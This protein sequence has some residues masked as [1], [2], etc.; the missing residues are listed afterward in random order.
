MKK[1]DS[2]D[3]QKH[4][5]PIKEAPGE[6]N[7]Q[8]N[9]AVHIPLIS[10][11]ISGQEPVS[12]AVMEPVQ[13]FSRPGNTISIRDALNPLK[14]EQKK[15]IEA[16]DKHNS[17]DAVILT[18]RPVSGEFLLLCWNSFAENIRE[19]RPRMS[20]ALKSSPP[21]VRSEAIVEFV[22]N[23]QAQLEDFS[24]STKADLEHFLRR[25]MQNSAI[26]IE[27]IVPEIA[28]DQKE[29]LY[30]SEEKFEYLNKKNP[31]LSKL[32]ERLNLELE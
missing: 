4:L 16:D 28:G 20:A 12:T 24:R 26:V 1:Q 11:E 3:A 2:S 14:T 6:I 13:K 22:L 25:E 17:D 32:K 9:G 23:N 7:V 29:K 18:K 21:R 19:E 30:T 5:P 10:S 8:K 31:L 27:A 15:D